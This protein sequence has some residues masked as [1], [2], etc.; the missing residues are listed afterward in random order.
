M[1]RREELLDPNSCLSKAQDDEMVFVILGRDPVAAPTIDYWVK[2][3]IAMGLN[4]END[5][6]MLAA[7]TCADTMEQQSKLFPLLQQTS[8]LPSYAQ[9]Q[10]SRDGWKLEVE[11]YAADNQRLR[12][13]NEAIRKATEKDVWYWQGDG[14]DF[15]ASL[16]C[17]VV[18]TAD[19][20]RELLA[21]IPKQPTGCEHCTDPDGNPCYPQTGLAPH[22]SFA[23][24]G[25]LLKTVTSNPQHWPDNFTPDEGDPRMGIWSCP[26]CG[27]GKPTRRSTIRKDTM[28]DITTHKVNGLNEALAVTAMDEP[29]PG[30]ASH[31]YMINATMGSHVECTIRFQNGPI[32]ERG[33]NGVSGEAILAVLIDRYE[34]FQA[35]PYACQENADA[36][37]HLQAAMACLHSR[38]KARI[39]RGVEGTMEK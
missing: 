31:L 21:Q 38:T 20:L 1:L 27:C 19:T 23:E 16:V 14:S 15:P 17:P 39:E 33:I 32:Q 28:R 3:R 13:E 5:P 29:G 6:Q 9:M 10:R 4:A 22:Q 36:L 37:T 25:T 34:D 30:G 24:D 26:K 35:G 2:A 7:T 18:M 8:Q 12:T 11:K